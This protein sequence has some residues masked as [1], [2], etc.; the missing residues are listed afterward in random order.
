[1]HGDVSSTDE[2][3]RAIGPMMVRSWTTETDTY[4]TTGP[5]FDDAGNLYVSPLAPY[6]NVVLMSL[7]PL[8]GSRRWSIAGTTG[9]PAGGAAPMVIEDPDDPGSQLVYLVLYDRAL[10]VTT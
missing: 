4:Q 5:V 6:E 1:M 3:S 9:A 8:D 2:I 10:A 7:D